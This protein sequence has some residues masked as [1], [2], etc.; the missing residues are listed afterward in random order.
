MFLGSN[1]HVMMQVLEGGNSS[2]LP[3][4]LSVMN[5]YTEMAAGSK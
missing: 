4:E 3:H 5:T 2:C 1:M